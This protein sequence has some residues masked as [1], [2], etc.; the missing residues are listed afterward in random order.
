MGACGP[1]GPVIAAQSLAQGLCEVPAQCHH[2]PGDM[3]GFATCMTGGCERQGAQPPQPE[4]HSSTLG[5]SK[6]MTLPQI[7]WAF[8]TDRKTQTQVRNIPSAH[9]RL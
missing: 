8:N 1:L 7:S 6:S 2:L 4:V 9:Q 3:C 5:R